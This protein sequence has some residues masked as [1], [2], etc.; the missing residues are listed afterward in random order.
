MPDVA[1]EPL[2]AV[3]ALS[4]P[5]NSFAEDVAQISATGGAGV[6]L[7]EGKL[8]PGRDEDSVSRLAEAGLTATLCLPGVWSILPNIRFSDPPDPDDRVELICRSVER[9]AAFTPVAVMVTPGGPTD[10]SDADTYDIIVSGLRRITEAAGKIGVRV[11]L[12]PIR[13]SSDGFVESFGRALQVI[14]DV[15]LDGLGIALDI[16]HTWDDPELL[17]NIAAHTGAIYGVQL[18]DWRE[19]TRVRSDRVLPGDGVADVPRILAAL[20]RAGYTGW[21]ELEVMS[22][23]SLDGSL[24]SVPHEEL[25][26]TAAQR[27]DA[28]WHAALEQLR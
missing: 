12:E 17:P 11:A 18:N 25:L 27:F 13:K 26:R 14:D 2:Y 7:W 1:P 9:L 23:E 24:W 20:V 28:V 10:R 8:P 16:W 19:P 6:G 5:R 3:S 4:L 21:Y 15:G 22:D